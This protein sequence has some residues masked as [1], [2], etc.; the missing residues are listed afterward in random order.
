MIGGG[1]SISVAPRRSATVG[2]DTVASIFGR[3]ARAHADRIAAVEPGRNPLQYRELDR[4]SSELASHIVSAG[5][6]PGD[7]VAVCSGRSIDALVAIVA[8]IRAGAAYVPLDPEYPDDQLKSLLAQIEPALVISDTPNFG[9][10]QE[11]SAT[12]RPHDVIPLRPSRPAPSA[13]DCPARD[14]DV[15]PDSPAYVMFTSGSTGQ[16]KGVVVPHRAIVRLVQGQDFCRLS[17][18]DT[19]LHFAPLNFDASTLEIWGALLNG[20]CVAILSAPKPSARAIARFLREQAVTTAWLTAGLF[21]LMVDEELDAL[22]DLQQLL[23]GGD[24]LSPDHV[25]RFLAAAPNCRLVNG[26]GPTE[27]TT[28][29]CCAQLGDEEW[30]CQSAPIGR[31]INGTSVY[32]VDESMRPV[33]PGEPG[34]LVTG[35][36]GLAIGYLR[37]PGLTARR[38]VDAPAPIADRVYLTGDLAREMPDGQFEFLGRMDR[39]VKIDGKR[40]EPGEIEEVLRSCPDVTDAAVVISRSEAGVV[41]LIAFVCPGSANPSAA[42]SHVRERL[43]RHMWPSLFRAI[44]AIPLTLNGKIDREALAAFA[45]GSAKAGDDQFGGAERMVAELVA[46]SPRH[47][48]H[49]P[50]RPFLRPWRTIPSVHARAFRDRAHDGTADRN[51][52]LVCSADDS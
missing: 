8:I 25:R 19:L 22:S 23:A 35:G 14:V 48:G 44:D 26:Y 43:P 7:L 38:F 9:R 21:H 10:M 49:R 42:E 3:T 11:L 32:I 39:Q 1:G 30:P 52:G 17:A 37:D 46:R 13:S 36:A 18:T 6:E 41:R 16:P 29:T 24:V 50:R 33:E 4:R 2:H 15:G 5:V 47:R 20:G 51:R 40:V 12:S 34:Q 28:F 27:N 31:P 45:F